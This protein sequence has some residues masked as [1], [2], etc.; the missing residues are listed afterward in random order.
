M[1]EEALIVVEGGPHDG[2]TVPL[3]RGAILG[4][5]I[6]NE[7][8]LDEVG[9]SRRHA[10][11]EQSQGVYRLRDLSSTNGT[12]VNGERLGRADRVLDDV[13]NDVQPQPAVGGDRLVHGSEKHPDERFEVLVLST[14]A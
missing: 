13:D 11:I 7:V 3:V 12:F 6:A 1:V 9:V 14:R 4:R 2:E 5:H 8:V 10:E